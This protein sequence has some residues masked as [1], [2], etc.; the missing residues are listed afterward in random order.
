MTAHKKP[1]LNPT[2]PSS[3]ALV[4]LSGGSEVCSGSIDRDFGALWELLEALILASSDFSSLLVRSLVLRAPFLL[5]FE[6]PGGKSEL[7][8]G[9]RGFTNQ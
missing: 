1:Q 5:V 9:R 2:Q 8:T 6:P 4:I 3:H 7:P